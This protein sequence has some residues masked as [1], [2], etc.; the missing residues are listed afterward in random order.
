MVNFKHFLNSYLSI[1][2]LAYSNCANDPYCAASAI[3]GYMRKFKQDCNGDGKT[4][5]LDF[6][7]IHR[8]GGYGCQGELDAKYKN[9]FDDCIG[10][11]LNKPNPNPKQ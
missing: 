4:D 8:F 7:K 1:F 3:Q 2:L 6:A 11:F 9:A 5:C 10:Y